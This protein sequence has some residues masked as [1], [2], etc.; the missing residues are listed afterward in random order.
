MLADATVPRK[1]RRESIYKFDLRGCAYKCISARRGRWVTVITSMDIA[2]PGTSGDMA[3]AL[4]TAA[5]AGQ[6]IRLGGGFTKDVMGGPAATGDVR[7]ST[8]A[9]TRV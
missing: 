4:R 9:L 8:C 2:R 5:E 6:K 1:L 7:I 3:A